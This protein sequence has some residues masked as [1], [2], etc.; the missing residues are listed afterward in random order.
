M[1]NSA[2]SKLSKDVNR[3]IDVQQQA[4][5]I[6]SS[7]TRAGYFSTVVQITKI[8]LPIQNALY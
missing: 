6:Y 3:I 2:Y 5:H 8:S 7:L 1:L 4:I